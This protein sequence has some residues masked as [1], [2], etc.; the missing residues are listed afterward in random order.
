MQKTSIS[1]S[2]ADQVGL[3]IRKGG[4]S[5]T[6]QATSQ[7]MKNCVDQEKCPDQGGGSSDQGDQ[8]RRS[9]PKRVDHNMF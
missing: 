9:D 1:L 5:I 4:Q 3:P 8:F 6:S 7:N 2:S